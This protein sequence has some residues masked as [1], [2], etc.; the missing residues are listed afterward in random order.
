MYTNNAKWHMHEDHWLH[1]GLLRNACKIIWSSDCKKLVWPKTRPGPFAL[2]AARPGLK[3]GPAAH[4]VLRNRNAT[5]HGRTQLQSG[6]RRP[7]WSIA[8]WSWPLSACQLNW[9]LPGILSLM[10]I[11]FHR[12]IISVGLSY[13]RRGSALHVQIK[14]MDKIDVSRISSLL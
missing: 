11:F 7:V 8:K 6:A 12:L 2:N 9:R 4:T 3:R 14:I 10:A 1:G 13:R 5:S